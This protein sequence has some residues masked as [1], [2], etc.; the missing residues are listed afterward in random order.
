MPN[1]ILTT[2][3]ISNT[4]LA[5]FSTNC[6]FINTASRMYQADF[7]SSGYQIGTTLQVKRQNN[8]LIGDGSVAVPQSIQEQVEEIKV[9]HQYHAMIEYTIQ[10]LSLRIEDF[11]RLFLQPAI[12][13]IIAKMEQ[14]I[15]RS[16][17]TELSMFSGTAGTPINSFA[18]I[19]AAGTVLLNHDI[20]LNEGD[21]YMALSV[22][23]AAS[24]KAGLIN[25]FTPMLNEEITRYS[26]VGHLSYFDVFQSQNIKRHEAGAGPTLFPGDTLTV[27]GAVAS[28]ST[29]VLAGATP[30]ITN[31]FLPGDLI[32]IAGV[33]SWA[34]KSGNTYTNAQFVILQPANSNGLG[35]VTIQVQILG[36]PIIS[37]PTNSHR[38]VSNPV[39]DAAPVTVQGSYPLNVAYPTRALDIVCPPLWKLEVPQVAQ[40][41][42]DA[43]GL[44]LTVTQ[45]GNINT[46]QN[47]MRIDLLC[48]FKWHPQ[49]A[50]KV[51]GQ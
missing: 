2:Q 6:P 44:S 42:D 41:T 4:S 39:P 30:N 29:I 47:L 5:L 46:Y 33:T 51:L 36:N 10:D 43:T 22:K 38:N 16:A 28:G 7:T 18:S 19:D 14:D 40:T 13:G 50:C 8:Y 45:I 35:Q 24:A 12:Q 21:S 11:S 9:E 23:E 27:N 37:D 32:S 20:A 34:P 25:F 3:L 26:S 17:E 48:G 49:Y 31:Y 1:Q 15:S